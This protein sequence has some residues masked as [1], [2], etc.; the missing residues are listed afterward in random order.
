MG[1]LRKNSLTSASFACDLIS[2]SLTVF[3]VLRDTDPLHVAIGTSSFRPPNP[4]TLYLVVAIAL[5]LAVSAGR[6][7]GS[8][9]QDHWVRAN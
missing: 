4:R 9:S 1:P 3:K 2:T 7:S 6:Q 5:C 8:C